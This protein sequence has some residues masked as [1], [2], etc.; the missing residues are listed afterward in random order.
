MA[1]T[2]N[3][4]VFKFGPYQLDLRAG[5]L[6][7]NGYRVRLQ[8]KPML[9]LAALLE[10]HGQVVTRED[11][12]KRLWPADTFV[13]FETGLNTAVSKLREV[14]SDDAEKPRYV[15][16]IPRRG[17][18][19]VFPVEAM[20]AENTIAPAPQVSPPFKEE[21]TFTKALPRRREGWR[22]NRAPVWVV[23]RGARV[24]II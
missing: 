20:P 23:V 12:K 5:E 2:F 21:S 1:P 19:F 18:R 11:L 16:T 10:Q 3:S 7:R 22:W 6:R 24:T 4:M 9:L 13:D 8:E 15:E 14:L 17:Y